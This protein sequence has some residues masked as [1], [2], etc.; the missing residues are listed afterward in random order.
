MVVKSRENGGECRFVDLGRKTAFS[1]RK[2]RAYMGKAT[3]GL[4]KC[5]SVGAGNNWGLGTEATTPHPGPPPPSCI[6]RRDGPMGFVGPRL[7]AE[8]LHIMGS[9]LPISVFMDLR[10]MHRRL[11]QKQVDE[12]APAQIRNQCD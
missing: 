5:D 7:E 12:Q 6:L 9:L 4:F 3:H 1:H 8:H 2:D 10:R 11:V